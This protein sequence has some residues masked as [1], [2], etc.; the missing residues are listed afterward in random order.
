M[1]E[2]WMNIQTWSWRAASHETFPCL[3]QSSWTTQTGLG[4]MQ[5]CS[6]L[7][8]LYQALSCTPTEGHSLRG[9]DCSHS[10]SGPRA[11]GPLSWA[12]AGLTLLSSSRARI[13]FCF[14]TKSNTFH[15]SDILSWSW[16]KT[17]DWSWTHI[18]WGAAP[19]NG[20]KSTLAFLLYGS[21]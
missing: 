2:S 4:Q 6:A 18:H 1:N 12:A 16:S 9:E 17:S 7:C 8:M 19:R 10:S 21:T 11:G 20:T 3:M 15:I 13:C 5:T 14:H